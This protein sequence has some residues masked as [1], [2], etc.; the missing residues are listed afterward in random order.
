MS[1]EATAQHREP[2]LFENFRASVSAV[3]AKE[4][5]WR[6]RGRRAF[7]LMTV[8]VGVL[9]LVV[10]L[11]YRVMYD[12][13]VFDAVIRGQPAPIDAVSGSLSTMIGQSVFTT[14]LIT[15]TIL[16]LLLAPALTSGSI[17]MEREKQTLELLIS[18][19]VSTLGLVVGKLV[20]SL[21]FVF[22]LVLASMPLMSIVFVF[23][24]IAPDDVIRAYIVLFATTF[25]IGSIGLFM[26]ALLKR[27]QVATALAYVIVF[28]VTV[29]GAIL[30]AWMYA[31]SAPQD[32]RMRDSERHAPIALV[33]F[34][35]F[36]AG[37]DV[38]CSAIPE[39]YGFTCSYVAAVTD[40]ERDL[41]NLAVDAPRDA[42]WPRSVVALLALGALLTLLTTQLIAPSRR[43]RRQL[44]RDDNNPGPELPPAPSTG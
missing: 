24:G 37:M 5:R 4:A 12:R 18:T 22:L 16:T 7:V 19:P 8:Y 17:S 25:G 9:A 39:S 15:Q 31:S 23:G 43:I 28:L 40:R 3:F 14:I 33:I 11:V 38:L 41:E 20:S 35:P 6:M 13:A 10:L 42:F 26:S 32:F 36:V 29:V 2:T 21:A 30:H 27:T 1:A 34:N 44:P